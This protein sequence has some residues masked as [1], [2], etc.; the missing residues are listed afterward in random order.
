M[1]SLFS[2]KD[3]KHNF[4]LIAFQFHTLDYSLGILKNKKKELKNNPVLKH[5]IDNY[6]LMQKLSWSQK[7]SGEILPFD[8]NN[9]IK[10]YMDNPNN[11]DLK[12]YM[13]ICKHIVARELD[14]AELCSKIDFNSHLFILDGK[15]LFC[16]DC[17]LSTVNSNYNE[18]E[19]NFLCSCAKREK[20]IVRVNT[21]TPSSGLTPLY[22]TN[23]DN[24]ANIMR[25]A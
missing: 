19:K 20:R 4:H 7:T 8:I 16:T 2:L 22:S 12:N 9:T 24:S 10:E 25:A 15:D 14:M 21:G 5:K 13:N 11:K 1:E 17:S 3:S 23:N 18:I 6:M